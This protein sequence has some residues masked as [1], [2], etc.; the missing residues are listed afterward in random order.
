ML[1]V[2]ESFYKK[3]FFAKNNSTNLDFLNFNFNFEQLTAK[4][5]SFTQDSL[6]NNACVGFFDGCPSLKC[7]LCYHDKKPFFLIKVL[8]KLFFT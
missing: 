3:L 8:A 5:H 2:S 4:N 7:H 6:H 1:V